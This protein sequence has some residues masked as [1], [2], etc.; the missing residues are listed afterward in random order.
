MFAKRSYNFQWAD[1]QILPHWDHSSCKTR[2]RGT[3]DVVVLEK[4]K[5]NTVQGQAL[6]AI[7]LQEVYELQCFQKGD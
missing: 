1:F 2:E 5:L 6:Q 4:T 3:K 7:I